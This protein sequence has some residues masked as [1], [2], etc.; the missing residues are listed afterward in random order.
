MLSKKDII[1]IS[2]KKRKQKC[3]RGTGRRKS[4]NNKVE[5]MALYNAD[6]Q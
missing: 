4:G 3:Q 1:K 5:P 6:L 2:K